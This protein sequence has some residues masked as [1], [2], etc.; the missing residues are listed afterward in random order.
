MKNQSVPYDFSRGKSDVGLSTENE[1]W[2]SR[3]AHTEVSWTN[4]DRFRRL[5]H[6]PFSFLRG[7]WR[8]MHS[9][10]RTAGPA[11]VRRV[12]PFWLW[13]STRLTPQRCMRLRMAE[14]FTGAEMRE[15][16]GRR[17]MPD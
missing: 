7:W 12:G 5:Q 10:A 13:Q 16:R 1:R 2:R 3:S 4:D 6:R 15:R 9:R 11:M 17:P 14:A 8:H